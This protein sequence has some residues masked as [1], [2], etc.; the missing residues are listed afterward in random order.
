MNSTPQ[1]TSSP[2]PPDTHLARYQRWLQKQHGLRFDN[3]DA[4][5]HWSVTELEAFWASV[6]D[7]FDVES[8]TP[9]LRVLA[10][11]RMQSTRLDDPLPDGLG[12]EGARK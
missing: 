7:Y 5:W 1:A 2:A 4:L 3:Y 12:P 9:Y 11:E 8:P 6:W 10:E